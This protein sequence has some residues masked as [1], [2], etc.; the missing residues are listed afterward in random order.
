MDTHADCS[1]PVGEVVQFA[2]KAEACE[3]AVQIA[4]AFTGR[5]A[6]IT[7]PTPYTRASLTSLC[8]AMAE[9]SERIAALVI[10]LEPSDDAI[11]GR[12]IRKARE[13][14]SAEGAVLIWCETV[15]D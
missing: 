6:V 1:N 7:V 13:L 10:E 11:Y 3:A 5:S 14:A 12:M 15:P 2:S 9:S 4:R 8:R